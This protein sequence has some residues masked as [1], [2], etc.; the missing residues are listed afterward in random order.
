[1]IKAVIFDMYE[2]L[3]TMCRSDSYKGANIAADLGLDEKV[4]REVWDASESDRTVG[5]RNFEETIR[6]SMEVNDCFSDELLQDIVGKRSEAQ[7][8]YFNHLH[9]EIIPM[10]HELKKRQVKVALISNCYLEER[11][12]I[13]QSILWDY[14]DVA[15]LSCELGVKKPQKEIFEICLA[16]LGLFAEECL[17]VGDGGSHELD[18][19]KELGMR[20]VQAAWYLDDGLDQPVGRLP[21]FKQL[22]SP[23][24]VPSLL[25]EK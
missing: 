9:P 13:K 23:M 1:M 24:D 25:S 5:I 11:D 6:L 14:F 12:M 8:E 10:L 18:K 16:K 20:A 7:K 21:G 15:C 2:T 4:C 19:A 17:Y 22:E 3:V